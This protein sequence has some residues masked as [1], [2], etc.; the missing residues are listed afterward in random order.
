MKFDLRFEY[1]KGEGDE[2]EFLKFWWQFA[3]IYVNQLEL[4]NSRLIR[5]SCS[6]FL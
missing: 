6:K 4:N 5:V 2:Y 3:L 1:I